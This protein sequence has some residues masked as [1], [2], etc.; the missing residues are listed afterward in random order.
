M[1]ER[2]YIDATNIAKLRSASA[3]LHSTLAMSDL[4]QAELRQAL[5]AIRRW[6]SRLEGRID[7]EMDT[8]GDGG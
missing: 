3:I 2:D 6:E 8:S 1:R 5:N 7:A 4:E